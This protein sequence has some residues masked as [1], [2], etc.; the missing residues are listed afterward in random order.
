MPLS[1]TFYLNRQQYDKGKRESE[2]YMTDKAWL[3]DA[4]MVVQN[5]R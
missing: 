2:P 3:Q 5:T 4:H 1:E